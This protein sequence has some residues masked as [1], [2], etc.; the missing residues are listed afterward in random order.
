[1]VDAN[2]VIEDC[3]AWWNEKEYLA[4]MVQ[5]PEGIIGVYDLIT[6]YG[7]ENILGEAYDCEYVGKR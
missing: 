5:M 2:S 6:Y 7:Y 3:E 4:S 1:M